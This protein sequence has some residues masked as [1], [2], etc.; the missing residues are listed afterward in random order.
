M[1]DLMVGQL[2]F[3]IQEAVISDFGVAEQANLLSQPRCLCLLPACM[4][5]GNE[6]ELHQQQGYVRVKPEQQICVA[7]SGPAKGSREQV[8][9]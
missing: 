6:L 4:V 8:C 3:G 9:F 2:S 1:W 5:S 7:L